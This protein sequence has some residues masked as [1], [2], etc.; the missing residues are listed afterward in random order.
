MLVACRPIHDE[1]GVSW[2]GG[3][4]NIVNYW[5]AKLIGVGHQ[6]GHRTQGYHIFVRSKRF[7]CLRQPL[8]VLLFYPDTSFPVAVI[9]IRRAI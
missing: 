2:C 6:A 9:S 3:T 8:A 7:T 5:L 4:V 1:I